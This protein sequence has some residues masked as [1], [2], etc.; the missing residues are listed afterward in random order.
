PARFQ[1]VAAM[2]PCP[3]GRYGDPTANCRCTPAEIQR[4]RM[5][6]SAPLLDRMDMHI[7]V[8]R[9]EVSEFDVPVDI[10]ETTATAAVRIASARETQL[11]RQGACNAR[12]ADAEIDR[13][14]VPDTLGRRVLQTAM[15]RLGFSARA[16]QRILKLARTIADLEGESN[17]ASSHVSE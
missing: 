8:P 15:Q 10:A 9:V 4:Y 16:R 6:I 2:N 3:C 7:E 12:L 5:R 14:C 11:E 1:L 13:I 17:V